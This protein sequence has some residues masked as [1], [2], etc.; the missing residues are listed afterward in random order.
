MGNPFKKAKPQKRLDDELT[1]FG[2]QPQKSEG[3]KQPQE[4]VVA[5]T[6]PKKE[7]PTAALRKEQAMVKSLVDLFPKRKQVTVRFKGS[8]ICLERR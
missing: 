7:L 3:V 1:V 6:P 8:H 2:D 4:P 5:P